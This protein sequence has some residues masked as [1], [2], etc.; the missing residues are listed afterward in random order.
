M[1]DVG[2]YTN[3]WYLQKK[4]LILPNIIY[5]VVF[6]NIRLRFIMEYGRSNYIYLS[7]RLT[8]LLPA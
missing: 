6:C 4:N 7:W 5:F 2:A 8:A 1:N 3:G